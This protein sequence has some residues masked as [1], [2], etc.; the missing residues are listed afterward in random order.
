MV[1]S[2]AKIKSL[3]PAAPDPH[4]ANTVVPT[5]RYAPV[6]QIMELAVRRPGAR[7]SGRLLRRRAWR[8]LRADPH[9]LLAIV[10]AVPAILV[11]SL[12]GAAPTGFAIQA[13]GLLIAGQVMLGLWR[14]TPRWLP[15]VRLAATLV[16]V[17]L[18]NAE[19][20]TDAT[21]PLRALV[22]P[23]VAMAAAMG[24]A[25][26]PDRR[27]RGGRGDDRP[28]PDRSDVRRPAA[29]GHRAHGQ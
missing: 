28:D 6:S 12:A 4:A 1:Q 22:V 25:W 29:A 23:I 21:G 8:H 24:G 2:S 13:A 26:R 17:L 10:L 19:V 3:A 27:H 7:R 18:V 11:E 9:L 16:F 20:R 15:S 14:P 5:G